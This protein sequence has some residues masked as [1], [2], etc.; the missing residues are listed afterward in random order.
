MGLALGKQSILPQ[1]YSPQ[2]LYAIKRQSYQYLIR[3]SI[4]GFDR[5]QAYEFSYLKAKNHPVVK[6]L[7]LDVPQHSSHIAESKSLKLYL[8]GFNNEV[9]K[10]EANLVSVITTDLAKVLTVEP[11]VQ[12][13]SIESVESASAMPGICVDENVEVEK[14]SRFYSN[15]FRSL[16]PV[17]AQPDWATI[18]FQFDCA[19]DAK[20]IASYLNALVLGYRS[21]EDFHEHCVESMF[22]AIYQRRFTKHH[23]VQAFFCRRGGIDINPY[24]TN[25]IRLEPLMIRTHRQ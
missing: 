24:R 14:G 16:C 15:L 11:K 6:Y 13:L 12:L 21:K 1:S 4:Y 7:I 5:W 23:A 2:S 9:I 18:V 20:P 19:V 8:H 3:E 22:E 17:T 10:D 25:S